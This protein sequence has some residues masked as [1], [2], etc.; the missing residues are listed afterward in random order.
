[1]KGIIFSELIE[2]VEQNLGI[3]I[4]DQMIEGA[5]TSN[6]GA[7]TAVGTYDHAELIALVSSLSSATS[8]PPSELVQSFG[9]HLF[10]RLRELYP[11]FF[12]NVHSAI[13]FLPMVEDYIHVEVRKLYPDAE[14]PT[15]ECETVNGE[16]QI[17]Y[18]STRPFADLAEGMMTACVNHFQDAVQINREDLGMQ[19][20]T[21]AR[22][23][24]KTVVDSAS[25]GK[26][27]V[28]PS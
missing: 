18:N 8:K 20:G 14:L 4:A 21:A 9:K 17:T 15:F 5:V 12:D 11:Q 19:D 10:H 28:C 7:Y 3:E 13:E 1:M 24:L 23:L 27:Q 26:Q 25:V 6:Q 22:F 2:M 16:L